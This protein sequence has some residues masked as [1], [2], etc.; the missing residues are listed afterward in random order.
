M[1]GTGLARGFPGPARLG[2]AHIRCRPW[3]LRTDH[4][5]SDSHLGPAAASELALPLS[6]FDLYLGSSTEAKGTRAVTSQV[7]GT[8]WQ[9][10][11]APPGP[12]QQGPRFGGSPGM[13]EQDATLSKV[14][15]EL[16]S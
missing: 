13:P 3:E 2:K 14:H 16:E 15:E 7:G 9:D 12:H 4:T 10:S 6:A 8:V 11:A 5:L 1:N